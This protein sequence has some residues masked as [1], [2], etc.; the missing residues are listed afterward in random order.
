MHLCSNVKA[1]LKTKN[2]KC[3]V[4]QT[5]KAVWSTSVSACQDILLIAN[6]C[7]YITMSQVCRQERRAH[8]RSRVTR[9]VLVTLAEFLD[10]SYK[11]K[12]SPISNKMFGFWLDNRL[13]RNLTHWCW[14]P[15]FKWQRGCC[16]P[17]GC[18]IHGSQGNTPAAAA[19]RT[20]PAA[21]SIVAMWYSP[22]C[23]SLAALWKLNVFFFFGPG[24]ALLCLWSM[25]RSHSYFS[26]ATWLDPVC[27]TQLLL[28]QRHG[29]SWVS[30]CTHGS[31]CISPLTLGRLHGV[32]HL[33]CHH[34]TSYVMCYSV[35]YYYAWKNKN[36]ALHYLEHKDSRIGKTLNSKS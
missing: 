17:R 12:D 35:F 6:I 8:S 22:G 32:S 9:D 21:Q 11:A 1:N 29:N 24:W 7:M 15:W 5:I 26:S 3:I 28:T 34:V 27:T 23:R 14:G 36:R 2:A 33:F 25:F 4:H 19:S 16:K 10:S 13:V 18:V 30:G 31:G 20:A